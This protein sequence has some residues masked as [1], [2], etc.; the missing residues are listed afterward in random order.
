MNIATHPNS[1]DAYWLPFTAN[2]HFKKAPRLLAK[3]A[4][5]YYWNH[6][7]DKLIDGCAGLFTSALGHCRP[8]I[9]AAVGA[10]LGELDFSPPFQFANPLAFELAHM[11]AEITPD[12]LNHVFFTGGGSESVETAMKIALAYHRV[13]G[14]AQRQRFVGRE[15]AYHGVNFGGISI[16]GMVKN[17]ESYGIG[18]PGVAHLRHTW[19]AEN[20]FAPGQGAHGAELADD[21]QRLVDLHG[22]DSIAAC[23]V[24]PIAGSTGVLVPPQGYLQRLRQICDANGILL[25]FDEVITGFGRTGQAFGADCFGVV[26]D[27]MTMAKAITNGAVPMGA[28]VVKDEIYDAVTEAV[29]EGGI[30][31]FHGYTYSAHPAACAAGIATQRIYREEAI[32]ARAAALAPQFQER[33]FALQGSDR[34]VDIRGHGLLAGIDL[35]PAEKPGARGYAVLQAAFEAGLV[36]RVTMDTVILAPALIAEPDHLD[37]ILD[38]L[39]AVIAA[40]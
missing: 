36:L 32:F 27:I 21:L 18:L 17:R 23:F 16:G 34:V 38:K 7:G 2:R 40:T 11:V 22:A 20:R 26:P 35:A 13:R 6:R 3:G 15:R 5:M 10:Q 4:G 1:L 8:E 33:V 24:E 14:Q 31:L 12:G 25:V 29:P 19:L 28:V 9:A 30:E 37:E 39:K